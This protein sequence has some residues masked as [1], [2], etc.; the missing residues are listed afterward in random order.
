MLSP[1]KIIT[2]GVL[3]GA[4]IPDGLEPS[5]QMV[6]HIRCGKCMV[7]GNAP[8]TPPTAKSMRFRSASF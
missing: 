7:G 3:Q 2:W 6:I 8:P 4:Q 1:D 5:C